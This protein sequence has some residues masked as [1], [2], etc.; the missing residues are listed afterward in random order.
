MNKIYLAMTTCAVITFSGCKKTVKRVD[1]GTVKDLSGRFN[2]ID[3]QMIAQSIV[4][5]MLF[6]CHDLNSALKN[7][8]ILAVGEVRNL[9]HEHINCSTFMN[10]IERA[11]I[12]S[13]RCRIVANKSIREAIQDEFAEFEYNLSPLDRLE[14]QRESAKKLG[15]NR[16]IFSSITSIIDQEKNESVRFYQFDIKLVDVDTNEIVWMGTKKIKKFI[17]A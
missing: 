15:V 1:I 10:D 4:E 9:S 3:S 6:E 8:R 14:K 13:G 5:Q 12:N 2:D 11:L 16:M 17:K 7:D